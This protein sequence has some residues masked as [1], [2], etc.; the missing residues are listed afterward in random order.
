MLSGIAL[1]LFIAF[2]FYLAALPPST[3]G[4]QAIKELINR[5]AAGGDKPKA[6]KRAAEEPKNTMNKESGSRFDFYTILPEYEVAI[7]EEELVPAQGS[8]GSTHT[9]GSEDTGYIIQVGSF[10][11][12]EDA[13][14]RKA[15]LALLGIVS[16]IQ[17]VTINGT[18]TWHRVRIGPLKGGD[19]LIQVRNLLQDNEIDYMILREKR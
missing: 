8:T 5:P 14:T 12:D 16:T 13:D 1:G 15:Q 11:K 2:L 9:E 7:P 10:R 4:K 19:P 6:E 18:E 3:E 17:T